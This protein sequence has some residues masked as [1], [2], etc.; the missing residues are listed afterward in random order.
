MKCNVSARCDGNSKSALNRPN[1]ENS[2]IRLVIANE[3]AE[4]RGEADEAAES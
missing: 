1:V 3:T 2:L 4:P